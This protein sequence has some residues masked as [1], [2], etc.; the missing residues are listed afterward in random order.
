M[1]NNTLYLDF[2]A[3]I[4]KFDKILSRGLCRGIGTVNGQMCI[5]AA[6]CT[7]L[8]LPFNDQPTCVTQEIID[9]KITLNDVKWSSP[10]ARSKG[11]RNLGIAQLG[12]KEIVNGEEFVQLMKQ[13]FITKLLP[14][15]IRKMF[16]DLTIL[17]AAEMCEIEG[18]NQSLNILISA[19]AIGLVDCYS[20]H[21]SLTL[22][23]INNL[24]VDEI[25][26]CFGYFNAAQNSHNI[27]NND[28]YLQLV[29]Q[30]TLDVL[31]ELKS[32]GCE[33]L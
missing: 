30:I 6:I 24:L 1:D 32:P 15:H 2:A 8:D 33:W 10:E 11:L 13:K 17:N 3:I 5:E 16:N 29:A 7:A 4:P 18:S 12:S 26:I 21:Y 20:D 14:F 19:I 25:Q 31:K 27:E 22:Y 23:G 9:F 28:E